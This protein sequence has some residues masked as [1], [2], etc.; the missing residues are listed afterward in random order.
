MRPAPLRA[1]RPGMEIRPVDVYDDALIRTWHRASEIIERS[2][3]PPCTFFSEQELVTQLREGDP[4]ERAE[5]FTAY[6]GDDVVGTGMLYVPLLDNL[7]KI[8]FTVGVL[9]EHR[10]KGYGDALLEHAVALTRAEQRPVMV[11][12]T[13]L[14]VEG[15]HDDPRHRF[16]V[17][18]GFSL[19]NLEMRRLLELPIPD[20]RLQAWADEAAAHHEGYRIEPFVDRVPDHL[21]PSLVELHN[22][23]AVDA[24]T[25]DLDFEAGRATVE[26]FDEQMRQMRLTGREMFMT[27]AIHTE[28]DGTERTVAHTTMSCP[29][30]D[31]DLPFLNQWGTFVDRS[32]RGHRLGLAVKAANLRQIQKAHPERTLISTTNSADNGPM[33]AINEQMGFRPVELSAE[34]LK[35][36]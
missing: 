10:S 26:I 8:Y 23:L 14:P 17:R 25:G 22:Q 19:A 35:R 34:Y 30:G 18:H 13:H 24:P 5:P 20:E 1:Y 33:V 6:V 32:H 7:D 4:E 31:H 27:L 9:P 12:W 21:K 36:L 2:D 11:G 15:Y 28:E 16:A 3:R 29:P